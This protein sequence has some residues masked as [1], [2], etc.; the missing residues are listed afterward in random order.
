M[1]RNAWQMECWKESLYSPPLLKV[2]VRHEMTMMLFARVMQ[3]LLVAR[4]VATLDV[5]RASTLCTWK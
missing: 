5:Q 3:Q 4:A 1:E 2:A